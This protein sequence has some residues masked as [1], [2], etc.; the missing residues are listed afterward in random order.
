MKF[1]AKNLNIMEKEESA[2]DG[3]RIIYMKEVKS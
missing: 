1:F 2:F 3:L